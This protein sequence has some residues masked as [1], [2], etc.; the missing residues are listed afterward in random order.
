[1]FWTCA[2]MHAKKEMIHA[3]YDTQLAQFNV[4]WKEVPPRE[5]LLTEQPD[6]R[7]NKTHAKSAEW[8]IPLLLKW[9]RERR[10]RQ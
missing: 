8:Y 4:V 6:V 7:Y 9:L 5:A 2:K 10:G 1:M 3:S